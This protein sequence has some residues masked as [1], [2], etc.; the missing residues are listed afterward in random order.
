MAQHRTRVA[1]RERAALVGL[2]AG[3]A[4]RLDAE[5]SLEELAGLAEAAGAEVVLRMLQEDGGRVL[6][7]SDDCPPMEELEKVARKITMT[8]EN[9]AAAERDLRQY[10]VLQLLSNHI[11]E[12]FPVPIV[13]DNGDM[14]G[15]AS[16][17]L[18][19]SVGG[20]VKEIRGYFVSPVNK[21][22]LKIVQNGIDGCACGDWSVYLTN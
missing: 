3:K 22:S 4:R 5:R 12:E 2:I 10:L 6:A 17:H 15:W 8:E 11:G 9:A 19:G 20:S 14:I 13:D 7:E 18:T 16:F 1:G 21:K